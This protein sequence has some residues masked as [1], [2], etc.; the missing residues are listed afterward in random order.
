MFLWNYPFNFRFLMLIFFVELETI[1][2]QRFYTHQ[3]GVLINSKSTYLNQ[4]IHTTYGID[5]MLVRCFSGHRYDWVTILD[6][7]KSRVH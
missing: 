5:S 2:L 1:G 4:F 3:I 7:I 6:L